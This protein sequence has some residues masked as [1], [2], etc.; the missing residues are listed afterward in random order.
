M[1]RQQFPTRSTHHP[2]Y[3]RTVSSRVSGTPLHVLR[4]PTRERGAPLAP[5]AILRGSV[6]ARGSG[7]L[8]SAKRKFREMNTCGIEELKPFTISTSKTNELKP[9]EMNTY[10]KNVEGECTLRSPARFVDSARLVAQVVPTTLS[11]AGDLRLL[12]SCPSPVRIRA[13][14]LAVAAF[15]RAAGAALNDH[16]ISHLEYALTKNGPGGGYQAS[17]NSISTISGFVPTRKG[18]PQ[19]PAPQFVKTSIRPK[20]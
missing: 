11:R 17:S 4:A 12:V 8:R 16:P 1:K 13:C 18:G 5:R 7:L 15:R 10:A 6:F 19:V 3:L 14:F 2:S 9:P 20:G